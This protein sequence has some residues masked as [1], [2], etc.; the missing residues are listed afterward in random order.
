MQRGRD[1]LTTRAFGYWTRSV[2][3]AL[4]P[5][6]G[7]PV[8][9]AQ[10]P[11]DQPVP[12][13]SSG[14]LEGFE[15]SIRRQL[16]DARD[17]AA[18][19]ATAEA[20]GD[21]GMLL[22]AYDRFDRAAAC[23]AEARRLAPRAFEWAYSQGV[24]LAAA[25][26]IDRAVEALEQALS[27]S[28]SDVPAGVRLAELR[29]EQGRV[30]DSIR[31]YRQVIGVRPSSALAHYG[32]GRALTERNDPA[33]LEHY[34]R[35][36]ALAP[37]LA[38]AHYALALAYARQGDRERALTAQATYENT[39]RRPQPVEDP[40]VERL[41]ARR[42]GP[43]E[44]L[45]RGRALLARGQHAEA[46]EAFERAARNSPGLLQAHV[47]LVAAYGAVGEA[48][49]A[50][51]AYAA[52]FAISPEL[53][54]L[55]YN[56]GVLRLSQRRT[57]EA[58]AAF[59]RALAGNPAYAD[60]HNNL[61]FVLAQRGSTA[62]A[63]EHFRAAL[64]ASPEHRDAHFNLARLLLAQKDL[65]RAILHF[66]RAATAEDEKTSLYLY[67]LADAHARAGRPDDAE[68][69]AVEARKRAAAYGQTDLVARIDNDLRRLR[70]SRKP[71]K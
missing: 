50:E 51:A 17:R 41:A 48:D 9:P 2:I 28:P 3:V 34:E 23:Y 61:G 55:H 36:V 38:A 65:E 19:E 70:D 44:D 5:G 29:L 7:W 45:A 25:G 11:P 12:F 71:G 31:L 35:A 43:F 16:V 54:D 22:H 18:R 24:A 15:P 4:L 60:A 69:H 37:G 1:L 33:A 40:L 10:R 47:N 67:H 66:S 57:D 46:I 8:E 64:S 13:V 39:R 56:L 53:P 52:A 6:V 59:E 20:F 49:K 42:S 62:D 58:I 14:D 68:R 26:E 30:D 63:V 32:L 21:L 27:L